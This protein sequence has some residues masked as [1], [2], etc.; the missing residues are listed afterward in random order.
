[1][2]KHRARSAT[3]GVNY[4]AEALPC[5]AIAVRGTPEAA[6]WFQNGFMR[7]VRSFADAAH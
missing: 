7:S 2:V 6:A 5:A 4:G 1:L 3:L